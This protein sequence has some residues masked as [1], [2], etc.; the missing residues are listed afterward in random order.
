M[1][2]FS[3]DDDDVGV[4]VGDKGNKGEA[5]RSPAGGDKKRSSMALTR[6]RGEFSLTEDP[7]LKFCQVQVALQVL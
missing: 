7:N 1:E 2:V 5:S 4:W 3:M 6:R